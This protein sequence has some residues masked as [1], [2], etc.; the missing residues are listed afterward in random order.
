MYVKLNI[1]NTVYVA[2]ILQI[3]LLARTSV[4]KK[5]ILS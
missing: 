4:I 1:Y 3:Y 5:I 2:V